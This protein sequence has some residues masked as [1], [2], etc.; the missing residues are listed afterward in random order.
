VF[1]SDKLL[2]DEWFSCTM[3]I[4]VPVFNAQC[5]RGVVVVQSVSHG[6]KRTAAN[7]Q[8]SLLRQGELC[9]L[10]F[11]RDRR[12]TDEIPFKKALWYFMHVLAHAMGT[13]MGL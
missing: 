1:L 5:L 10:W 9:R 3:L 11:V 4:V 13:H 7:A 2:R 12:Q 6:L 8:E